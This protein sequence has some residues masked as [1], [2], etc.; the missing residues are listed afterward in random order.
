LEHPLFWSAQ[1]RLLFLKDASDRL[2]PERASSPIVQALEQRASNNFAGDWTLKLSPTIMDELGAGK[3]RKY[4]KALMTDLLR[5]IRNKGHHYRDL[6]PE[7]QHEFGS[8]PEGFVDF[9][10]QR[11]R[12]LLVDTYEA[13]RTFCATE[14]TFQSYYSAA[15]TSPS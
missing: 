9:F 6:S 2:D 1:K 3:H 4:N 13:L 10:L 11:Y 5:V 15:R 14:P 12:R 8:L 7:V